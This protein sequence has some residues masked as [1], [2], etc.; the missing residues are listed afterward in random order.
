MLGAYSYALPLPAN[1]TFSKTGNIVV[2][3]LTGA[4][5]TEVLQYAPDSINSAVYHLSSDALTINTPSITNSAG[6]TR[7]Y[8]FTLTGGAVTAMHSVWSY[9][10]Q[11]YTND[12]FLLPTAQLSKSGDTVTET[13][14]RG[15]VVETLQFVA[16]GSSGLYALAADSRSFVQPGS[17]TTLL[18]VDPFDRA[19][20]T[21]DASGHV[22]QFQDVRLDGSAVAATPNAYTSFSQPAP[23][24]VLETVSFGAR[25]S[26][27]VYHDGNGDGIYTAIAHGAGTTVDLVGLQSQLSNTIDAVL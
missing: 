23:G 3:T 4:Y 15:N 27:E 6:L 25:S 20:F 9:G 13:L 14:V 7:G 5:A 12:L 21:I 26:Y 2:E 18:S 8:S 1:A 17:A 11:S 10:S 24:Y 16:S 19:R 22:L